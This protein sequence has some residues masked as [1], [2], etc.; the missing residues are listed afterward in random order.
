MLLSNYLAD[1]AEK[2]LDRIV[3]DGGFTAIFRR[4]GCIGD[5]LSSGEFE[6]TNPEMTSNG[7]HDYFEYSWGQYIARAAGCTVLNFS[8]GGM[9]AKEYWNS[10][11]DKNDYWNPDKLCQAYIIAL[12]VNDLNNQHQEI[13][14]TADINLEDYNKNAETFTGYYAR[15]IQRLKEM[16]P[17]AR[18]FLMTM[19]PSKKGGTDDERGMNIKAHRKLLYELAEMFDYTY[20]LDMFEYAPPYDETFRRNFYLGGHM[21][22]MGYQLTA[23]MVMSYIDYIVRNNMEDFAQVGFIGKGVHNYGAKW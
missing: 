19:L 9:T 18:F 8:R 12:G 5:S 6:S 2:P 4:I 7:Y 22:P 13:G 23:K 21:N 10:F 20:V 11:A 14:A 17:Q 16:Q 1:P 3:D 15:I